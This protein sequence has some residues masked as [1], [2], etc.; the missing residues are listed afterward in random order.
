MRVLEREENIFVRWEC[1]VALGQLGDRRVEDLLLRLQREEIAQVVR[2]ACR[3]ALAE[4][5]GRKVG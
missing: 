3:D 4:I 2:D 5:R 1:I